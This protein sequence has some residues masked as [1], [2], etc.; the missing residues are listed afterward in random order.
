MPASRR[1]LPG[2]KDRKAFTDIEG[3]KTLFPGLV[4]VNVGEDRIVERELLSVA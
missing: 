3:G 4:P 1:A 2:G